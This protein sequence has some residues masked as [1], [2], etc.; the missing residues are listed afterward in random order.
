MVRASTGRPWKQ[1]FVAEMHPAAGEQLLEGLPHRLML[2]LREP[3]A[4]GEAETGLTQQGFAIDRQDLSDDRF[5]GR[6]PLGGWNRADGAA[7]GWGSP[8]LLPAGA[9]FAVDPERLL[10]IEMEMPMALDRGMRKQASAA[11]CRRWPNPIDE[12][13][14]VRPWR[15]PAR[16]PDDHSPGLKELLNNLLLGADP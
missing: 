14:P 2:G 11:R 15:Q 1:T 9:L 7:S 12:T 4:S 6:P 3:A 8:E 5:Q 10:G 16:E 13:N